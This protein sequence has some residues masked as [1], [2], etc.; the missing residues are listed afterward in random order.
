MN[1]GQTIVELQNKDFNIDKLLA[2]R[3]LYSQ[4][5]NLQ[6]LLIAFV[7]LSPIIIAFVNRF[8]Q[9]KFD[10]YNWMFITYSCIAI[11]IEKLLEFIID[12]KKRT[13]AA[14]QEKFDTKVFGLDQNEFLNTKY[15]DEDIIRKFSKKDRQN[16]NK[17]SKVKDWYSIKID[18]LPTNLAVLF[19]QRMNI[20]YD[21]NIKKQYS[22]LLLITTAIT[23]LALLIFSML[24][25][26]TLKKFIVEV[27]LPS[28]PLFNFTFKEIK[29]SIESTSN[30]HK[31]R[32]QIESKISGSTFLQ[33]LNNNDLRNIQDR[34][35]NNR[36]LS[37]L[38]PDMIYKNMWSDLE[39]EMNYSVEQKIEEIINN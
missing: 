23:F 27:F 12:E 1:N 22:V 35:Y 33:S 14:I 3:R 32:E 30:L 6:Y 5:K 26:F 25:G 18:S 16:I 37:P 34:I 17:L 38:I 2:Q 29:T 19:C 8:C 10:E 15:V 7:V 21:Q 36:I 13:A 11:L 39:D 4:G 24:E 28:L 9:L 20:T 31:L